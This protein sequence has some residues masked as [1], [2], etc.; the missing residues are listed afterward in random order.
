MY[1]HKMFNGSF[2]NMISLSLMDVHSLKTLPVACLIERS[3]G[4]EVF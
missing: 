2:G 1:R 4:T 3:K